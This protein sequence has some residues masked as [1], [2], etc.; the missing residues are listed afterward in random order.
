VVKGND[1]AAGNGQLVFEEM[2]APAAE[3][4]VCQGDCCEVLK[5]VAA[6]TFTAVVCD[7]PYGLEFMGK[8][9][10]KLGAHTE[11]RTRREKEIK[12]PI[13]GPYIRAGVNGY[14]R[15]G[16]AMQLWH[17]QWAEAVLRVLKPGG[18]L[19]A[20]GGTRTHHRLI[21]GLEDAGFEIRDCLM[22]LYGSGFPKSLNISKA[23]DKAAG[24]ERDMIATRRGTGNTKMCGL[25]RGKGF[26]VTV[27]ETVPATPAAKQWDGYGTSLKPAWEPIIVAMKPLDGTFAAN[28]LKHGVAGVNVDGCR[29]GTDWTTDP[30][31]RGWQGGNATN[32][33]SIFGTSGQQIQGV[34]SKPHS[35]GR[36]PANLILSHHPECVQVGVKK[37]RATGGGP[38]PGKSKSTDEIYGEY[39]KRSLVHHRDADGLET[40]EAWDCHPDCPMGM[41]PE[42]HSTKGNG[43][44]NDPWLGGGLWNDRNTYS[45]SGS[46]ARFFYCAKASRKERT[47]NGQVDNK[48]PTV[49]PLALMRYLLTLVTYPGGNYILDPFCGS[50]STLVA[51]K[52][53]GLKAMGIDKDRQ[54]VTLSRARL[55][56]TNGEW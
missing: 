30:T 11:A 48:H 7:P 14:G 5:N 31:R 19:L 2:Q 1:K 52:Q 23:I 26:G 9:W 20:F 10:D 3:L 24:A 49:K 50:G 29:I 47:C 55:A 38:T 40:V 42:S 27:E 8:E 34:L 32:S 41:F 4:E 18:F 17:Q 56:D 54:S 36:F 6:D 25:A 21:C 37:V 16:V 46:A 51:C 15:N 33:K 13:K 44:S 43:T 53:L 22:W 39:A 35:S 12:H 28:A 45:D